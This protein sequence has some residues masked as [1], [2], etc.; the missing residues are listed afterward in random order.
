MQSNPSAWLSFGNV[1][2]V[3]FGPIRAKARFNATA[4]AGGPAA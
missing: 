4:T 1:C 2:A 3:R